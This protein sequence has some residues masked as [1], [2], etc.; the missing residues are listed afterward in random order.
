M[1]FDGAWL[2]ES[3]VATLLETKGFIHGDKN[4]NS[5]S[6]EVFEENK[7]RFIPD[8]WRVEEGEPAIVL[9]T[10]YKYASATGVRTD[11][12]QVLCYMFLMKAQYGGLIFPPL[13][14]DEESEEVLQEVNSEEK[15]NVKQMTIATAF[16]SAEGKHLW[17]NYQFTFPDKKA[18]N[19]ANAFLGKMK[20]QEEN[21]FR[22]LDR[23]RRLR[24]K[25]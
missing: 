17:E 8:F 18:V 6:I 10:K 3:Y 23:S 11:I 22:F 12:H 20:E 13:I 19:D 1:L 2:W 16:N 9:D 14:D 15:S 25:L 21:L 24:S 4:D 5:R 7:L